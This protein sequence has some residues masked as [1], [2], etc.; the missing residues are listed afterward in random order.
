ML[1]YF[2][3]NAADQSCWCVRIVYYDFC[4]R[5]KQGKQL[6]PTPLASCKQCFLRNQGY[7]IEVEMGEET[8]RER[9]ERGDERARMQHAS[10]LLGS[11]M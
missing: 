11:E 9:G 10:K 4:Q 6:G 7:C 8:V 1:H 5:G 3:Q 2:T